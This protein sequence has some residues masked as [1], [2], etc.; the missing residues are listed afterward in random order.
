MYSER[1]TR[2]RVKNRM[3]EYAAIG[4]SPSRSVLIA[5]WTDSVLVVLREL[6]LLAD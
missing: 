2:K 1:V 6:P 4:D 5:K 3:E